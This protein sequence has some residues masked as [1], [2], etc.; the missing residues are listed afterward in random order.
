M[1][2]GPHD[3]HTDSYPFINPGWSRRLHLWSHRRFRIVLDFQAS[4]ERRP[5]FG[6]SKLN[7]EIS[8]LKFKIGISRLDFNFDFQDEISRFK[9]Q[10]S[11]FKILW[12][13]FAPPHPHAHTHPL[14]KHVTS[15]FEYAR[16]LNRQKIQDLRCCW[17]APP[18]KGKRE[19]AGQQTFLSNSTRR[20]DRAYARTNETKQSPG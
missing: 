16:H 5:N 14:N 11:R 7:L 13:G 18:P 9:I 4:P 2:Y 6:K 1:N 19:K 15:P 3:F 17:G 12:G 8:R 20:P 10:D